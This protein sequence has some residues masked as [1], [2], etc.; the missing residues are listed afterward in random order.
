MEGFLFIYFFGVQ[1][2]NEVKKL[3]LRIGFAIILFSLS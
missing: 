2:N 3:N 1:G